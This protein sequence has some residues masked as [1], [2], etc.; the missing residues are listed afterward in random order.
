[1]ETDGSTSRGDESR[2]KIEAETLFFFSNLSFSL[3]LTPQIFAEFSF[4]SLNFSL[5]ELLQHFSVLPSIK[6]SLELYL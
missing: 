6:S 1:M 5:L 3:P 2:W 4:N